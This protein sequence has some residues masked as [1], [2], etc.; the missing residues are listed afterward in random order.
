MTTQFIFHHY[1]STKFILIIVEVMYDRSQ[2]YTNCTQVWCRVFT[3][4]VDATLL[5]WRI[6]LLEHNCF[7]HTS[8][9]HLILTQYILLL[10]LRA[11]IVCRVTGVTHVACVAGVWRA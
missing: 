3:Y 2:W 7:I 5:I 1:W 6:F 9:Y 4:N 8:V 10:Y 11:I